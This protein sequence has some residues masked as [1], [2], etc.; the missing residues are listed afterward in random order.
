MVV[1][2][3]KS[4]FI[5]HGFERVAVLK[6]AG[7]RSLGFSVELSYSEAMSGKARILRVEGCG[8]RHFRSRVPLCC[9][10][11]SLKGVGVA[12]VMGLAS[13]G[14]RALSLGRRT[15]LFTTT[16]SNLHDAQQVRCPLRNGAAMLEMSPQELSRWHFGKLLNFPSA[17]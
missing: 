12:S 5:V 13:L 17:S 14:L 11:E 3:S 7:S 2:G 1:S 16:V 9:E 10:G 8:P 6:G 4:G 15:A